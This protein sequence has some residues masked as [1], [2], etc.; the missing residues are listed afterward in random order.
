MTA[1]ARS[2]GLGEAFF[3]PVVVTLPAV[4]LSVV[5]GSAALIVPRRR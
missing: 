2:G 5:G 1:S 4:I 3:L